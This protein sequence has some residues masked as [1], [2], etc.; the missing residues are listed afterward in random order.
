MMMPYARQ[1]RV[2]LTTSVPSSLPAVVADPRATK[3]ILFNLIG[4]AV[5]FSGTDSLVRVDAYL[6]P[7]ADWIVVSVEDEGPG[8][9]SS[10]FE[11]LFEPLGGE[12]VKREGAGLGLALCQELAV[13]M[14]G[15]IDVTSCEGQGS[16]FSLRVPVSAEHAQSPGEPEG[17]EIDS[18]GQR[19]ELG[20]KILYVEDEPINV[21]LIEHFCSLH[22]GIDLTVVESGAEAIRIARD[23]QPDLILLDINLPDMHGRDVLSTLRSDPTTMRTPIVAFSADVSVGDEHLPGQ[24][25]FDAHWVKPVDLGRLEISLARLLRA[26]ILDT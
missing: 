8:M 5:K 2:S 7:S 14:G 23:L 12:G 25:G 16:V 18:V 1:R 20:G 11:R 26:R 6:E 4:N 15:A 21:M 19:I 9:P 3:Q 24:S 13:A 10:A 22:P 17:E